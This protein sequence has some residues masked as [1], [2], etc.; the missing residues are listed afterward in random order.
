MHFDHISA[1][2]EDSIFQLMERYMHDPREEKIDLGIGVYR[3]ED[4]STPPFMAILEAKKVW[5]RKN[6]PARYLP[7]DGNSTFTFYSGQLVFGEGF[8]NEAKDRIVMGQSVGG[9]GGLYVIAKL[10]AASLSKKI[11][12]PNF[13]WGNHRHIF[14]EAGME[15]ES[16]PYYSR[17]SHS[18]DMVSLLA[19]LGQ[20]KPHSVILFHG[21]CHNPTGCDPNIGDWERILKVM[22][23]KKLFPLFD[24][25]YQGFGDG[26]EEDASAIRYFAKSGIE[27]A[28]CN[29]YSKIMGMYRE[30]V[31]S[32]FLLCRDKKTN[33]ALSSHIKSHIRGTYSNPPSYGAALVAEVLE[34]MELTA[35]WKNELKERRQR[36]LSLR[37]A[38]EAALGKCKRDCSYM[39][40]CKGLFSLLPLE[41]E[42]VEQLI[43]KYGIYLVQS[44]RINISGLNQSNL[45]QVVDAI[46]NITL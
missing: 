4:G 16:Y 8:F 12:I 32:Y 37:D 34:S 24:L 45:T 6:Q 10:L 41:K 2:K 35:I 5:C 11:A 18:V 31:G 28:V 29:S 21:A 26:I 44:G 43:E 27:M 15:V 9:S 7:I 17:E 1:Q 42:E 13:T 23:E 30:R 33:D 3:A 25:A 20:A 19:F 46:N 14:E 22:K 36:V 38:F 40:E 39:K